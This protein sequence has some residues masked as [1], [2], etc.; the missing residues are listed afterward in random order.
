MPRKQPLGRYSKLWLTSPFTVKPVEEPKEAPPS[1]LDD[2]T[3]AGVAQVKDGWFVVLMNKKKRDERVRLRPGEAN[4]QGFKV[5][6]V[7]HG[8]GYKE[9][10]VRSS[11]AGAAAGS[12]MTTSSWF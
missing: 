2:Y 1:A 9:T 11:L 5:M 7:T 12:G 8:D 3:L 6:N 4:P 10:K